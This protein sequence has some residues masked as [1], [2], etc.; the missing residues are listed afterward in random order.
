MAS[1]SVCSATVTNLQSK[2][3]QQMAT[4]AL[5]R[6]DLAVARQQHGSGRQPSPAPGH[7]P[8]TL[9]G[10]P[11]RCIGRGVRESSGG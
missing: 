1:V 6:E 5:L 11:H 4:C 10:P 9:V 2:L 3:E 8:D 7:T